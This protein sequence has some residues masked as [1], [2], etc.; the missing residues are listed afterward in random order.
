MQLV[1]FV[2][3]KLLVCG[4][5]SQGNAI[6]GIS[7]RINPFTG[8]FYLKRQIKGAFIGLIP[9]KDFFTKEPLSRLFQ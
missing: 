3:K 1:F 8:S 7:F 2:P 5:V 6:K 9:V 4:F